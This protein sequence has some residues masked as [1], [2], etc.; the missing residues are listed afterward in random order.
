MDENVAWFESFHPARGT[1]I[2]RQAQDRFP[3]ESFVAPSIDIGQIDTDSFGMTEFLTGKGKP[4]LAV[5]QA[6]GIRK[7]QSDK[8]TEFLTGEGKP[9][10]A[11]K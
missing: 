8:M 5:R 3:Q 6:S 2:L 4:D 10:L 9:D 7:S 1:V 11:V